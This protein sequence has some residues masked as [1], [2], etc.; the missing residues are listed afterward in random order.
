MTTA[1]QAGNQI[2]PDW[3]LA[4]ICIA[5]LFGFIGYAFR[6]GTKV[7][8]DRNNSDFGPSFTG[9]DGNSSDGSSGDGGGHSF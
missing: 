7:K 3:I 8:P 4:P 9:S 6:Q 1:K 5:I 2:M